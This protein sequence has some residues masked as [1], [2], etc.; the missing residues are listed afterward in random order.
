MEAIRTLNHGYV[1]MQLFASST[2][3]MRI[4]NK[5]RVTL[6]FQNEIDA[7][8]IRIESLETA[9]AKIE[10]EIGLLRGWG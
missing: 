10:E 9:K 8:G 3:A 5:D 2:A 4:R 1:G 6:T 7:L